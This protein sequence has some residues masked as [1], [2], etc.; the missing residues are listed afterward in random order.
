M[1]VFLFVQIATART[2]PIKL[3]M[4][5]DRHRRRRRGRIARI[6]NAS[7]V[8]IV[9]ASASRTAA[10][11]DRR[12]SGSANA[13]RTSAAA[14]ATVIAKP[15]H[16]VRSNHIDVTDHAQPLH[17]QLRPFNPPTRMKTAWPS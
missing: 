5:V 9:A 8:R 7:A 15:S 3:N 16:P 6:G 13:S 14:I 2:H 11:L 17:L 12:D 1:H 10:T 4:V